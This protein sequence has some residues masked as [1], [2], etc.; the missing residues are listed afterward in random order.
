MFC[1]TNKYNLSN[2]I[3]HRLIIFSLKSVLLS[4]SKINDGLAEVPVLNMG[5]DESDML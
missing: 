4:V 3:N 2:K 1:I 5:D